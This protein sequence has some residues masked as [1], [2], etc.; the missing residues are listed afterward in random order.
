MK[1]ADGNRGA[2]EGV[3]TSLRRLEASDVSTSLHSRLL[4][5]DLWS[6]LQTNFKAK[7]SDWKE[8]RLYVESFTNEG[9]EHV[10]EMLEGAGCRVVKNSGEAVEFYWG[11]D[12]FTVMSRQYEFTMTNET[13]FD[14]V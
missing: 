14:W 7:W 9:G 12:L 13:V 5:K 2:E 11:D 6:A 1:T 4:H 10:A 8:G 3:D